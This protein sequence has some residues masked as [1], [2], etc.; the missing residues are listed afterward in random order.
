MSR[1]LN[2]PKEETLPQHCI[3]QKSYITAVEETLEA[4]P[5]ERCYADLGCF[6]LEYPWL[7]KER[8]FAILPEHPVDINTTFYLSTRY[9][10]GLIIYLNNCIMYLCTFIKTICQSRI[11]TSIF[12]QMIKTKKFRF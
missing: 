1:Y 12:E 9:N 2:D 10:L 8:P 5:I 11:K 6:G 4:T 3:L 7:S